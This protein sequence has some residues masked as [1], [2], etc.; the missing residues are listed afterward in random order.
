M[1][2]GANRSQLYDAQKTAHAQWSIV[3]DLWTD[4]AR[5]EFDEQ[6]WQPLDRQVSGSNEV[7]RAL[8]GDLQSLRIGQEAERMPASLG[9]DRSGGIEARL[10]L[11]GCQRRLFDSRTPAILATLHRCRRFWPHAE[12]ARGARGFA[13]EIVYARG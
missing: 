13:L 6:T 1:K 12:R 4:I 7:L 10:Q 9:C 3:C 11:F 8:G 5:Q 2:F